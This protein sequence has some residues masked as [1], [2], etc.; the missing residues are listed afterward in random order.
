MDD[1]ADSRGREAT[2]LSGHSSQGGSVA[3]FNVNMTSVDSGVE[4]GNDSNDSSTVQQD[5]QQHQ[6]QQQQQQPPEEERE[7]ERG[8]RG[9]RGS[10][11]PGDQDVGSGARGSVCSFVAYVRES[12]LSGRVSRLIRDTNVTQIVYKPMDDVADSR[13]REATPLSGHSSQGGSVACFNVNMTSVDSGVETGNDS[14]DSST[15]QQD[16][17]Q[18]QQQQQQQQQVAAS[19]VVGS[20]GVT[21][22]VDTDHS[23]SGEFPKLGMYDWTCTT[24]IDPLHFVQ[25]ESAVLSHR[26]NVGANKLKM[27]AINHAEMIKILRTAAAAGNTQKTGELLTTPDFYRPKIRERVF[28]SWRRWHHTFGLSEW[29]TERNQRRMRL[30]ATT[31]NISWMKRLLEYGV[32]PNNHDSHGR[33]PLHISA[34]RGYTEIVRLL[35]ENGADPNQRDCIGNTPLHLA[36][37]NSKLSVVTLLLTA[38]TDVLA[39]DSYGYNPLQLAKTKMR[40]LQRSFNCNN[41][42]ML[43]IKEE[44]HNVIHMLMAYLQK[45]KNMREQVETLSNFY[46]RLSLS[47]TTDQVQG[48]V[49]DLLANINALSITG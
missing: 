1:V 16:G 5:G 31:N 36:T 20:H 23:A 18:H 10:C 13:G 21:A 37:V 25:D 24:L 9:D 41:E 35:L 49:K 8:G 28:R 45:Q 11:R 12:R 4:T 42:D 39:L 38:G 7:R 44:M 27:N 22:S 17:Q 30:A 6:Q 19:Q 14:N 46:S 34:C 40:M 47:N 32:S 3:C 15:V 2:P 43:K 29:Q 48:D 26:H 33:T